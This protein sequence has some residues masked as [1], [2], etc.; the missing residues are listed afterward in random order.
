MTK[1]IKTAEEL[2]DKYC[3]ESHRELNLEE[4]CNAEGLF[5]EEVELNGLLGNIIYE[6]NYGLILINKS[7]SHPGMKR[8]T[9]THEMG[10]FFLSKNSN[11][12]KHGCSY[13]SLSNY[14]ENKNHEAEANRFAT[15]LLMHKPWF[16]RFIKNIPVCMDLIKQISEEFTVSLTA[17]AIRYA[18]IGQYPIAVIMSNDNLV[19][20][21]F[22][23]DSFPC[24]Y[25][26]VGSPVPKESNAW[27]YFNSDEMSTEEDLIQARCWFTEDFRCSQTTYFYEQSIAI[28][29]TKSVLTI[30]WESEFK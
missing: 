2:I 13:D 10:H 25:L 20:W 5:I 3:I 17:A 30:L 1:A 19:Q 28:P 21:A 26:P 12:N 7:I 6:N 14:S 22:I 23:N 15:E 8:F 4:I 29:V 11:I 18:E 9:I 16:S 27:D 24:R